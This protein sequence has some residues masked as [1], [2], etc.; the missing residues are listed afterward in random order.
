VTVTGG[1]MFCA[2]V[3]LT[4]FDV[5]ADSTSWFEGGN[6]VPYKFLRNTCPVE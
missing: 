3:E 6:K 4:L 2:K 5:L 1:G